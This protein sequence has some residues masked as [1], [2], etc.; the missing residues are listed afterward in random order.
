MTGKKEK[1]EDLIRELAEAFILFDGKGREPYAALGKAL[2]RLENLCPE[3]P[4][5]VS[6]KEKFIK[7]KK[8]KTPPDKKETAELGA[9][10]EKMQ[11]AAD[12]VKQTGAP[13]IKTLDIKDADIELYELFL[14]EAR[15]N[16][17]S[18][19][20]NMLRLEKD[21]S[22]TE[23]LKAVFRY[24][25]NIKGVASSYQFDHVGR[26]AHRLEDLLDQVRSGR[27]RITEEFSGIILKGVDLLREMILEGEKGLKKKKIVIREPDLSGILNSVGNY[28]RDFSVSAVPMQTDEK[29]IAE[30]LIS[31][32]QPS[33]PLPPSSS[34]LSA[35]CPVEPKAHA[36]VPSGFLRIE[37]RKMDQLV[38]M[39]GELSIVSNMITGSRDLSRT[40]NSPLEKSLNQ[41]QRITRG[42][43]DLALKLRMVPV[44]D[45]FLKMERVVRDYRSSGTKKVELALSGEET[46]MDRNM[47]EELYE[48]LV[49]LIRNACDHG[50]EAPSERAAAGKSETGLIK[51]MAYYKG[52]NIV[53]EVRDDGKGMDPKEIREKALEKGIITDQ[54]QLSDEELFRLIFHPGFSTALAVTDISGRGVGMDVVLRAVDRLKGKVEITTEK[55]KGSLFRIILPLTLAIIDGIIVRVGKEKFILPAGSI[56]KSFQPVRDYLTVMAGRGEMIIQ[57]GQFLNLI[58]VNELFRIPDAEKEASRGIVVIVEGRVKEYALFVDAILGKQEVVIKN[59]GSY[60]RQA[61]GIA[62]GAIL[63]D[64]RIGLILDIFDIEASSYF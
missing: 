56:R 42:I 19:E 40:G 28:I 2:S 50:L 4:F 45:T 6:F 5:F 59:L 48:P 57:D 63:S 41:F 64:G 44:K 12:A 32:A 46:E 7:I 61:R 17:D 60:L 31:R 51:L 14:M 26:L 55:G 8:T 49:H 9:L 25:H 1:K 24:F 35:A 29:K 30:Q 58:R 18:I 47:V 52:K 43:E 27:V 54:D 15:E 22:D 10:I 20:K 38:D 13:A 34:P 23:L 62:G 39:I 36:A 53:I 16:L 3:D 21:R 11:E 33:S 37:T